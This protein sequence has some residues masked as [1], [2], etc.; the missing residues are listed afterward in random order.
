M[1]NADFTGRWTMW[2]IIF[3]TL[4]SQAMTFPVD[5]YMTIHSMP[6]ITVMNLTAS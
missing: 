4:T 3:K 6:V 5:A 1:K 2:T